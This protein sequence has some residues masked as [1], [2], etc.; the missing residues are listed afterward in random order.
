MED[1]EFNIQNLDRLTDEERKKVS[2]LLNI[3]RRKRGDEEYAKANLEIGKIIAN[4]GYMPLAKRIWEEIQVSDSLYLYSKALYNI[5]LSWEKMGDEK[6][7][8]YFWKKV[9][10]RCN[11]ESFIC[12]RVNLGIVFSRNKDY[13]KAIQYWSEIKEE[14]G[15]DVFHEMNLFIG[16]AYHQLGMDKKSIS[17]LDSIAL[18]DNKKYYAEARNRLGVIYYHKGN[19][20]KAIEFF[21]SVRKEYDENSFGYAMFHL[22]LTILEKNMDEE[23]TLEYWHQ[24]VSL[25]DNIFCSEA[26]FGIGRIYLEQGKE[27]LALDMLRSINIEENTEAYT[28][29]QLYLAEFYSSNGEEGKAVKI[30]EKITEEQDY[31]YY[32]TAKVK[33]GIQFLKNSCSEDYYEHWDFFGKKYYF[34]K[35]SFKK[36]CSNEIN[37]LFE[38]ID[39]KEIMKNLTSCFMIILGIIDEL[40]IY[41]KY[42]DFKNKSPE[43]KFAHYTIV[44]S[45]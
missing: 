5:G 40:K 30:W 35:N 41:S 10:R 20:K 21:S 32:L 28:K 14:D 26:K 38:K 12:S 8:I 3:K 42:L 24:V 1:K 9:E 4:K 11:L 29:A 7:A 16:V 19:I 33:I 34:G 39:N 37:L 31:E 15:S 36:S 25:S 27:N 43:R 2:N 17:F 23:G 13:E 44:K 22:G 18:E 6:K 45:L